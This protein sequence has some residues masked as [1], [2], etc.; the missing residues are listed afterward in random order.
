M[1]SDYRLEI[2]RMINHAIKST[3]QDEV[4][5]ELVGWLSDEDLFDFLESYCDEHDCFPHE[6]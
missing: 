6:E 5:A 1:K 2:E 4:F 3:S